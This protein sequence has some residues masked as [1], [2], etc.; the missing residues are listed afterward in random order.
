MK[1]IDGKL[2]FEKYETDPCDVKIFKIIFGI[3]IVMCIIGSFYL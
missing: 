1:M 2:R 3:V